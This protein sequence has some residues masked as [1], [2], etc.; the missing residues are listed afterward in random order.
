VNSKINTITYEKTKFIPTNA[1]LPC[2]GGVD[3]TWNGIHSPGGSAG[4][5]WLADSAAID[6]HGSK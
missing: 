4:I 3:T 1:G 2:G 5:I 6:A